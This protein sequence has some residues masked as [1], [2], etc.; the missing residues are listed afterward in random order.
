MIFYIILIIVNMNFR[1]CERGNG[2]SM[3]N[4]NLKLYKK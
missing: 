4:I 2:D 1:R 3:R